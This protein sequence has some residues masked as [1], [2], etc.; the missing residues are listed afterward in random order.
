MAIARKPSNT[1]SAT[2][3]AVHDGGIELNDSLEVRESPGA[4]TMVIEVI[5][6]KPCGA[7]DGGYGV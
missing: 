7:L 4:D 3:V 2:R 6:N 1:T 5:L